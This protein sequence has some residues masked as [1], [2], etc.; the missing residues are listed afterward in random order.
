MRLIVWIAAAVLS[1]GAAAADWTMDPAASRLEFVSTFE[2]NPATGVFRRFET[3]LRF[4]PTHPD[5]GRLDVVIAV[6]TAD[7]ASAEINQAIAGP[8]W[9]DA[10]KYPR[11]EFHASDIRAIGARRFLARGTLKL[12]GVERPVDVPFAWTEDGGGA[13]MDGE[14]VL[15]R[16]A[17]GIGTGEWVSA[18][19]I[20]PDV[21]IRFRVQLRRAG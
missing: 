13:R 14:L 18:K 9:F 17:F 8:E 2:G 15:S 19:V 6:A 1:T 4:D 12:K 21:R 7:M 10:A 5:D 3:T 16:G 20:G 11:A